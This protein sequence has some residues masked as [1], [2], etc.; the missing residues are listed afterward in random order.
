[1]KNC[2]QWRY[3]FVDIIN[4]LYPYPVLWKNN[5]DYINSSF[6][7]DIDIKRSFEVVTIQV[8]FKLKNK[9]IDE[10]IENGR[11]E[12]LVHIESPATSYRLIKT[13]AQKEIYFDL[14]DKYLL[15]TVSLCPFVVVKEKIENYYNPK[16]NLDYEGITFSLDIGNI[17]AIGSQY[18][19]TVEK[20]SE[21]LADVPSIFTVYKREDDDS[22]DMKVEINSDKIRI[23]LNRDVY[24]N[25]NQ[26]VSLQMSMIE[27]VNT[28][29]L[30][31][32]LIYVVEQ[33]KERT[34]EY[35]DYRWFQA[36]KRML[37]KNSIEL[38][39][40]VGDDESIVL[41][42]KI[43]YMPISKALLSIKDIDTNTE[44]E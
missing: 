26:I 21:E 39:D 44:D 15:G 31:P 5:D 4:R 25:Y 32:V 13:S 7:C 1:M 38:E 22:I 8:K 30:F 33:L 36:L 34:E 29:I 18:K 37:E 10:L 16:F 28:A 17:L 3:Q 11:A 43:M 23:G 42:Q 20:N 6:D 2:V 14:K 35:E 19:F 40:A 41:A 24:E 12:Y 27:T 9:L